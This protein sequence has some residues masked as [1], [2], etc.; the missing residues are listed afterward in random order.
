MN[1]IRN[2]ARFRHLA[3]SDAYRLLS[4][5]YY[6]PEEAFLEEKVFD[7]L[8]TA[9]AQVADDLVSTVVTMDDGFRQAGLEALT[10]DY[11][12]LFLGPF[13]ILAKPYG[14][15]YLDGEDV[16]MGA[17]TMQAF[18]LYREGGF[19]VADD[20]REVPDHVALE[21][22]FLHLLSFRLGQAGDEDER[23]RFAALKRRFL[24]EHLGRWVGNLA[25]AMR[26]GAESDFYRRLA[27]VTERFV[28]DDMRESGGAG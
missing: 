12:R 8:R 14:S 22:E 1:N 13:G 21:L 25:Q 11:S 6:E 2:D 4:A 10:L 15:V 9:M 27:E 17:S 19:E 18:A 26:E 24:S 28:R 3:R 23:A 20:F 7:Q 16:V 5:C